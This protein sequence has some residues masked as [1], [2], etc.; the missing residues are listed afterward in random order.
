MNSLAMV[1][2]YL[3]TLFN[4]CGPQVFLALGLFVFRGLT[5]GVGILLIVPLLHIAGL[6]DSGSQPGMPSKVLKVFD[7]LEISL[8]LVAV[9]ILY[10]L[11][12]SLNSFIGYY[13]S[14]LAG[15]IQE[16][17]TRHLRTTLYEAMSRAEWLFFVRS[18]S[19]D[20]IHALTTEIQSVGLATHLVLDLA[21]SGILVFAY[22]LTAF[23][24][25]PV[26]AAITL[27]CAIALMLML[28]PLNKKAL[29]LGIRYRE[30]TQAVSRTISEHLN[31]MKEIKSFSASH[32]FIRKFAASNL[33]WMREIVGFHKVRAK[34]RMVNEI[35]A[36]TFIGGLLYLAVTALNTPLV[37][38]LLLVFL[39][40][41]ILPRVSTLHQHFQHIIN[42]L[43]SF[44]HLN[45]M[46]TECQQAQEQF[47]GNGNGA[48][49]PSLEK[50]IRLTDVGFIYPGTNDRFTFQ[51]LNMQ[52]PAN[53]ITAVTG[54][55]GA[56]KSTLAD[57]LMGLVWPSEGQIR[58][59]GVPLTPDM[60]HQWRKMVSYVP[61]DTFLFHDTVRANLELVKSDATQA[62]MEEALVQASALAFIERMPKGLDTVIGERGK[63]LS[64]GE[65]QRIALA[66]ALLKK[67]RLLIFDEATSSLDT[68]NEQGIMAAIEKMRGDRT[69]LIFT[70]RLSTIRNAARVIQLDG[71]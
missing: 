4:I 16:T 66:R 52:I 43:P 55:S 35:G 39:F 26:M 64:G 71:S 24:L 17:V 58:I 27:V 65:R 45:E 33:A 13:Q 70:H 36:V 37:E 60:I 9:I 11:L 20:F 48:D 14:T 23:L 1:R 30:H 59:D 2:I 41:R 34:S 69:I 42:A 62:Q 56:G 3:K 7:H 46:I 44:L 25:S 29:R 15:K 19:P 6:I 54:P 12:V 38:I 21:G 32:V 5:Q 47:P 22:L 51:H 57:L 61:Q 63:K 8:N 50:E 40:S 18:K 28:N 49:T 67:P 68:E 53:E 31:G 10:I